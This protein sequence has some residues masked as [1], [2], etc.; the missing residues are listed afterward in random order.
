MPMV[1]THASGWCPS[2]W[3]GGEE[4]VPHSE[5]TYRVAEFGFLSEDNDLYDRQ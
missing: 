5:E 3:F 2:P 1:Y 4:V